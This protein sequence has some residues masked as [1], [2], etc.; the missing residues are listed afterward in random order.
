MGDVKNS[1]VI[2]T[3]HIQELLMRGYEYG[4]FS[5]H[6]S[7]ND[8]RWLIAQCPVLMLTPP[9][10]LFV[11]KYNCMRKPTS[12]P[13]DTKLLTQWDTPDLGDSTSLTLISQLPMLIAA[14]R[15]HPHA[16]I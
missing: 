3:T 10:T 7:V 4:Q 13:L 9:K 14:E 15:I 16:G 8:L 11:S 6:P 12:N 5:W 2:A 1:G